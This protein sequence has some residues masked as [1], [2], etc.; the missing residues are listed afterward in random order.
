MT[1]YY[2][3]PAMSQS[4]LKDLKKSPKHFWEKHLSSKYYQ[5]T[6][7]YAMHFGKA[8]RMCLFEHQSFINNYIVEP[9]I[10]RRT[11]EGNLVFAEFE[12]DIGN[13]TVISADDMVT[14]KRIRDAVLNKKIS[15]ILLNNGLPEHELYWTDTNT[16]I[17]CKAKLGYFIEPCEQFP[18]GLIIDLKTTINAEPSEFAKSIY[19]FGYYNQLAYYCKAVKTIYQTLD[20]PTFIFIAVEK[21]APFECS[22]L[23]G[24]EEMLEIGLKE[25]RRLLNLYNHCIQTGKWPGYDD[26]VQEI[27]LPSWAINKFNLEEIVL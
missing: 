22:F 13:K 26:K 9:N 10:D 23:A 27:G 2:D 11:K 5:D 18:N 24:N 17:K 25:N 6:E 15:R 20:Y 14:V 12:A 3:N 8:A 19:T 1:N 16:G 4:K 7:T 21:T